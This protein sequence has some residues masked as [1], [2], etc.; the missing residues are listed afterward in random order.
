MRRNLTSIDTKGEITMTDKSK[1]VEVRFKILRNEFEAYEHEANKECLRSG[2]ALIKAEVRKQAQIKMKE[3]K[4]NIN[5][6]K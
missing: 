3:Q 1:Y 5:I 6:Q 4:L 2:T